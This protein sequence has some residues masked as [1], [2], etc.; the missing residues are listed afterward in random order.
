M[1]IFLPQHRPSRGRGFALPVIS[2]LVGTTAALA[3]TF[4]YMM[5]GTPLA[6]ESAVSLTAANAGEPGAE[7]AQEET[8]GEIAAVT[9]PNVAAEAD[10]KDEAEKSAADATP[11]QKVAVAI[12]PANDPRWAKSS[13]PSG[14]AA[15]AAMKSLVKG[16]RATKRDEASSPDLLAYASADAGK[17][18]E[19]DATG[20][21]KTGSIDPAATKVKAPADPAPDAR[22]SRVNTAVNMRSGPGDENRVILVIPGG[23]GVELLGCD[24][25][26]KVVYDGRTGYIYKS[27]V[28]G[29]S[30]ARASASR[31]VK[32]KADAPVKT[33]S[34]VST[35][36]ETKK[37]EPAAPNPMTNPNRGR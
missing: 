28:G 20:D 31:S 32:K 15:L 8:D 4:A 3:A 9:A 21:E 22:Q 18:P 19:Q 26:C 11:P 17:L 14:A 16:D 6:D 29:K 37:P 12:P 34:V 10:A 24:S 36:E 27:F 35:V 1:A 5:P 30:K 13:A 33:V 25:W 7:S 23:A 2:A